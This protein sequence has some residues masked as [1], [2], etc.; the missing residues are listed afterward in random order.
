MIA[1]CCIVW[2]GML[3][4]I[5]LYVPL[6]MTRYTILVSFLTFVGYLFV[7]YY[8]PIKTGYDQTISSAQQDYI[9]NKDKI[10]EN[11]VTQLKNT[12]TN[13]VIVRN[14]YFVYMFIL[15]CYIS[16]PYYIFYL[17]YHDPK[18]VTSFDKFMDQWITIPMTGG[19]LTAISVVGLF[20]WAIY[21]YGFMSMVYILLSVVLFALLFWFVV[22]YKHWVTQPKAFGIIA[23]V[24]IIATI[25][26]GGLVLGWNIMLYILLS[27]LVM[28]IVGWAILLQ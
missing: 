4:G 19:I 25:V 20:S 26:F 28:S 18:N 10:D 3:V 17:M 9:N 13:D 7:V 22:F 6:S 2:F 24:G 1:A 23:F 5:N 27:L 21:T 8:S 15:L 12:W 11:Y 16:V 14:K